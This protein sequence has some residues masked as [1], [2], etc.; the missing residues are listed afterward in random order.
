MKRYFWHVEFSHE[1]GRRFH[2]TE[3]ADTYG[4]AVAH[5]RYAVMEDHQVSGCA[6]TPVLI[7]RGEEAIDLLDSISSGASHGKTAN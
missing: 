5:A 6:L 7:Q 2:T 4:R 1:D 3:L